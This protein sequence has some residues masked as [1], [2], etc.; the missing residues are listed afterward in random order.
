[1]TIRVAAVVL[2]AALSAAAQAGDLAW[3]PDTDRGVEPLVDPNIVEQADSL[4]GLEMESEAQLPD[5]TND[6]FG[7]RYA[8]GE[9]V[10]LEGGLGYDSDPDSDDY[11]YG[12]ASRK[13]GDVSGLSGDLE[14]VGVNTKLRINF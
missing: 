14:D 3:D 5:A 1:M 2:F 8:I 13:G 9:G 7:G 11:Y 4:H 12:A 6:S 10:H